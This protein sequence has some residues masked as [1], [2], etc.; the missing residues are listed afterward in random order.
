MP[1]GGL[2]TCVPIWPRLFCRPG[3]ILARQKTRV[4]G[5]P[6]DFEICAKPRGF[7]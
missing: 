6:H 3:K 1:E 7:I 2:E 4:S 5:C